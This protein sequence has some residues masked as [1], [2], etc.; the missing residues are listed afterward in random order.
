[1]TLLTV[2]LIFLGIAILTAMF[3]FGLLETTFQGPARILFYVFLIMLLS[4]L[5]V[6]LTQHYDYDPTPTY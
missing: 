4:T 5:V 3:G 2:G 6:A 1:M